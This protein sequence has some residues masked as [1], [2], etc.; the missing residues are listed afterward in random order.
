MKTAEAN[1]EKRSIITFLASKGM[2]KAQFNL[3]VVFCEEDNDYHNGAKMFVL[4]A[5]Q[6]Y[7]VAAFGAARC[8]MSLGRFPQATL[9]SKIV[10]NAKGDV[11]KGREERLE[12][13]SEYQGILRK[14]RDSCGGCGASLDGR[15]RLYCKGCKTYCYCGRGCQKLHW[16]RIGGGGHRDECTEVCSLKE[17]M[18]MREF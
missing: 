1:K 2:G 8:C 3:G 14:L 10:A 12:G 16:N 9:W 5:L 7:A 18:N 13:I 4:A 11:E 6:G 17:K 15:T